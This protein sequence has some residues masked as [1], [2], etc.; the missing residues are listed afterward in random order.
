[1][2]AVLPSPAATFS[3]LQR[4]IRYTQSGPGAPS[5][6]DGYDL[7]FDVMTPSPFDG[8]TVSGPAGP[9][10]LS[11]TG[12]DL[13][14]GS[15]L[16]ASQAAFNAAFPMGTYNYHLTNS[17]NPAQTQDVSIDDTV[18]T[19][20]SSIPALTAASFNGLQGL[21]PALPFTV[22]F[23]TFTPAATPFNGPL[24]FFAVV[25]QNTSS[26]VLLDGLQPTDGQDLIPAG[27]LQSGTPYRYILFFSNNLVGIDTQLQL[28]L[29]T[30]GFFSTQGSAPEP[31]TLALG[32][33]G[34]GA[35]LFVRRSRLNSATAAPRGR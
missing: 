26:I 19:F 9:F 28:N 17:A 18:E 6:P 33:L 3:I 24:A 5:T 34:V 8:G 2:A 15:G 11:P 7:F 4:D 21:N 31:S 32:L 35:L 12:A 10:A 25:D 30:Q 22:F 23:N 16:I 27:T 20:P 13:Q 29:R 14:F 1:L